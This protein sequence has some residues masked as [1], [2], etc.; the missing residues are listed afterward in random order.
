MSEIKAIYCDVGGV[1]LTNGWD[2]HIRRRVLESFGV[3]VAAFEARHEEPNDAWEKGKITIDEYLTLTVFYEPRNFTRETFIQAMKNESVVLHAESMKIVQ[4]LRMSGLFTVA[5]LNNEAMELNDYRI[6]QYLTNCF[7]CFFSSCYI[8]L[9][10]PHR[11]M[12][13]AGLKM[14]QRLGDECVFID[15]R[16]ENV[17]A[18]VGVGMHGIHFKNPEQLRDELQKLGV[19]AAAAT[20]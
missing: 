10:K 5:M 2:H 6:Q 7:D 4:G 3:D 12:Y 8:G 20:A 17:A 19:F 11:E 1:L 16:A 9:R 18:A 13:E 15:D 14:L